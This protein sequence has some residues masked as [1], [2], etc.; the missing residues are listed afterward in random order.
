MD[1]G[2]SVLIFPEGTRSP[3]AQLHSFRPGIGL[4]AQQSQVP[5]LPIAL[6]GLDRMKKSGW[7]R[8]GHL[9]ISLGE[10]IPI[11]A[12]STPAELTQKFEASIRYLASL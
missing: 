6:I 4:L 5:V 1:N 10:T 2:Y 9:E 3:D 12:H 8:S 11:D 7:L